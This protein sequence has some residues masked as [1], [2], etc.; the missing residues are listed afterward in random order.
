M[1]KYKEGGQERRLKII[2]RIS[3]KWKTV[4]DRISS[5]PNKAATLLQQCNNDPSQ[6]L[7]QLFIDC[8]F[9]NEPANNYSCNWRGI[10]ELLKDIDEDVFAEQVKK[11]VLNKS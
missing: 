10:I 1:L 5:N 7:R 11:A 9:T 6:C 8:F 4:A 2:A 3:S